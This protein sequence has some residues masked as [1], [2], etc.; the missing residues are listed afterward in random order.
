MSQLYPGL[1]DLNDG[2]RAR[3][4]AASQTINV[5]TG[6]IAFHKG[7]ACKNFILVLAGRVRVQLSSEGGREVILYRVQPGGTCALTTSCIIGKEEYPAEAVIEEDVTALMIPDSQFRQALLDSEQFRQFVFQGFSRRLCA[8]V[9]RMENVALKTID[10]RLAEHLLK[11]DDKSLSKITH[12]VLAAEIGT[13]R[14]VVSRKLKQFESE[15]LIR[16]SRGRVEIIDRKNLQLLSGT[17][18]S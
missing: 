2:V 6:A 15:G 11:G 17:T 10:Q 3:L 12:Q 9:S 4:I 8:I 16:S 14:E 7:D 13:A 5:P 1:G 18:Y